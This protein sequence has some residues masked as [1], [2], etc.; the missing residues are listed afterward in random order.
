MCTPVCLDGE[1]SSFLLSV[2]VHSVW[3]RFRRWHE[4]E[5]R[6]CL[7]IQVKDQKNRKIC[8]IRLE[9]IPMVFSS[10]NGHSCELWIAFLSCGWIGET[11][12]K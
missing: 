2:K 11:I 6:L 3:L 9:K 12:F 4:E 5:D 1:A 10:N 8:K 7:I